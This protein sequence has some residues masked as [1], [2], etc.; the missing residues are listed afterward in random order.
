V[1]HTHALFAAQS[2]SIRDNLVAS[3]GHILGPDRAICGGDYFPSEAA[4]RWPSPYGSWLGASP[5]SARRLATN[6]IFVWLREFAEPSR[7]I[8]YRFSAVRSFRPLRKR[9]ALNAR[10]L[11][12][13]HG[14]FFGIGGQ[15]M[16]KCR[17]SLR[18]PS[19]STQAPVFFEEPHI[20]PA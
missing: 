15:S 4:R 14:D 8:R 10:A 18:M 3:S 6:P 1:T 9:L 19:R 11:L 13:G 7:L 12:I 16:R 2:Q 5:A 17:S 20:P